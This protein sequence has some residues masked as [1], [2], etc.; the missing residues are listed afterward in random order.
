MT[1]IVAI[2][3]E[4]GGVAKTTT[5]A[6][7]A[8]ALV[9]SGQDVLVVDLDPQAN[10]TL[11]LGIPPH[12][13]RRSVADILLNAAPALSVSRET[14]IPGLDII[15][16]N[17]EMVY[18]ERFLPIRQNYTL[19][20]KRALANITSYDI[21][22]IDCPPALGAVTQNGI[23]AAN[24]LIIP[25]LAEYF[26]AYS[27]RNVMALVKKVRT[28]DN[29]NLVYKILVTL[30]DIRLNAHKSLLAQFRE[31]FNTAMFDTII[32]I[33]SKLRE[34]TIAGTPITHY[35]PSSRGAKQYSALAQELVAY[36]KKEENYQSA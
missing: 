15:P 12:T 25:T 18:A 29:P 21:I 22:L 4:K 3:N 5:V 9:K 2:A 32:Q 27:L 10:L 35:M 19:I 23:T 31:T 1:Y 33:D 17:T 7:L 26:S 24:M 36:A 11:A 13:V 20:L 8:G 16:S 14:S 28:E 34:C 6:S 30:F